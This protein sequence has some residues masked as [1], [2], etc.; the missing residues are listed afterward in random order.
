MKFLIFLVLHK[1]EM[2]P[3]EGATKAHR[4]KES[5]MNLLLKDPN[6]KASILGPAGLAGLSS[7][8]LARLT[9]PMRDPFTEARLLE[10]QKNLELEVND[11]LKANIFTFKFV[12]FKTPSSTSADGA[13]I[14]H[15]MFFSFKFY[16]FSAAQTEA[17]ELKDP[18]LVS[19][20][21]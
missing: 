18:A 1:E 16:T 4:T 8:D 19:K 9:Q 17:V 20:E 5:L 2:T 10:V 11:V 3:K 6:L 15:K 14:P 7:S 13:T 12:Q 21:D